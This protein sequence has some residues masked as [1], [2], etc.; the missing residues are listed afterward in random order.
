MGIFK[1]I[2][3]RDLYGFMSLNFLWILY[4]LLG[5]GISGILPASYAFYSSLYRFMHG[6][7][8][9]SVFHS[10]H[11]D[12]KEGFFRV[13][14]LILPIVLV[15]L[16]LAADYYFSVMIQSKLLLSVILFLMYYSCSLFH[17]IFPT[18]ISD[19]L[20]IWK[21]L[22]EAAKLPFLLPKEMLFVFLYYVLVLI[23][24]MIYPGFFA[25]LLFNIPSLLTT[26]AYMKV[27][28]GLYKNKTNSAY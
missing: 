25:V 14:L 17:L 19:N 3:L 12:F 23:L 20:T 10:F 22:K 8:E 28:K 7:E 24:G 9:G 18:M 27:E 13:N 4:T 15:L 1:K 2:S 5:L 26:N 16:I 21:T 11:Q 6:E